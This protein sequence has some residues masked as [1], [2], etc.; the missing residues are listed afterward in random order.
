MEQARPPMLAR[1]LGLAA[2]LVAAG[3]LVVWGVDLGQ[4]VIGASKGEVGPNV[5]RQLAATELELARVTAERDALAEKLKASPAIAAPSAPGATDAELAKLN[6]DLALLE[7][8]L[9]AAKPGSGLLIRG[10]QAR[11]ASSRLLHY[12][13]LLQYGAKKKGPAAWAGRLQ[14]AVTVEQDGK[15]SVLEYPKAGAERYDMTIEQYQR[16]DGTLELPEGAKAVS[17][18]VRMTEKGKVV[19]SQT[20]TLR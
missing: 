3:V 18:A 17:V 20:T 10:M 6:A 13:V 4:R 8:V 16:V 19:A 14:L 9:P 7:E 12:T 15:Q 5:A 2:V 11:M 1:V